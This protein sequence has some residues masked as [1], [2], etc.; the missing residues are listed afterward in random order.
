MLAKNSRAW[1]IG[2]SS[3]SAIDWPRYCTS[4]VA[5][6]KRLPRHKRARHRQIRQ[7]LQGDA[8]APLA[9]TFLAAASLDVEAEAVRLVATQLGRAR[10]GEDLANLV[11]DAGVGGRAG[12]RRSAQRR[13]IDLDD[14]VELLQ[15]LDGIVP[16]GLRRQQPQMPAGGVAQDIAG[17]RTFAGAADAGHAHQ[18]AQRNRHVDVLE[19]VVPGPTD[20]DVAS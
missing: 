14:L 19:V 20:D 1:A 9:L 5:W 10:G 2:M 13:L 6:L 16:A 15:S 11:V 8:Q 4:S 18:S 7:E 3:T 17:Q 12:T